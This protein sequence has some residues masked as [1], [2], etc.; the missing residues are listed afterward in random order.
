MI[1]VELFLFG[2]ALG[3]LDVSTGTVPGGLA[4]VPC[5]VGTAVPTVAV[6]A[7]LATNG[8]LIAVVVGAGSEFVTAAVDP[9]E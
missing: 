6:A 3:L 8:V 9:E 2:G 4:V 5:T 7:A 1:V